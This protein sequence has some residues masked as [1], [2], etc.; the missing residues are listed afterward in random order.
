MQT[1]KLVGPGLSSM[2]PSH[3]TRAKD[4]SLSAVATGRFL[5]CLYREKYLHSS[6]EEVGEHSGDNEMTKAMRKQ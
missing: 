1:V 6:D 4:R 5:F 2:S 3:S